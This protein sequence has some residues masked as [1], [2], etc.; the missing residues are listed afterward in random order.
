MRVSMVLFMVLCCLSCQEKTVKTEATIRSVKYAKIEKSAGQETHTFSGSV[1]AKNEVALSF[2]VGGTLNEVKVKLGDRVKKGQLIATLDPTEYTIQSNQAVAQKEGAIASEQSAA[3]NVKSA[4][5][6]L[7]NAQSSYDRIA[8]LYENNSVALSEYQQAKASLDAAKAQ[9]ESAQSQLNSAS[10]QV[11]TADQQLRSATNQVSYTR[12]NAPINGVITHVAMDANEMVGAGT[13]IATVSSVDQMLVEVGVPEIFISRFKK[14]QPA[15]IQLP[16]LSGQRFEAAVVEVAFA[17]GTTTTYP[18]KLKI[19][20]PVA[21]IRPGMATEVDFT[22]DK[23]QKIT[24]NLTVAPIKSVASGAKGNYVFRLVQAQEK[25]A[26]RAE[27]VSVQLGTITDSGY[28]INKGLNNG[29]YVAVAGLNSLYDGKIV[30]L[31]EK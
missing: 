28:I 27:K 24:N 16:S 20:N 3:A 22:M 23:S 6:Q 15:V 19:I 11:T 29:D 4:E 1:I 8:R 9:Y 2:K 5:S 18:V 10:T 14:G 12:L 25:G 31:L 7:I 26:Y 21:A 13:P 17:S 30:K